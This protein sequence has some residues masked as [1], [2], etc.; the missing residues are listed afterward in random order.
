ML[1]KAFITVL[2]LKYFDPALETF[3][4]PDAS[5]SV[6]TAVLSQYYLLNTGACTLHPI[7]F[8]SRKITVAECNYGIGDKELL[9]IVNA[10]REWRPLLYGAT[11]RTRIL[12]DYLNLQDFATK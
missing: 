9:A 7:A 11:S 3:M 5:D 6:V 10:F 1:K 4:E 2:I 12:L 8:Y